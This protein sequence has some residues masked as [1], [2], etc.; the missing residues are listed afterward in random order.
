MKLLKRVF[1]ICETPLPADTTAWILGVDKLTIDLAKMPELKQPG[2]GVRI[3]GR[4][5]YPRLLVVHGDDGRYHAIANRCTH[6]GRRLDV[7]AGTHTVQ[8]CSVGK[9]TFTYKGEF[10]GGSAKKPVKTFPVSATE[11][12]LTITLNG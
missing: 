9:S 6:M 4:G 10:V 7:M 1:G 11:D 8:C 3:E 2:S 5:L 12:L